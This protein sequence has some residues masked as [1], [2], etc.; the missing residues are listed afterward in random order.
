M[1][2]DE[3]AELFPE[4]GDSPEHKAILNLAKQLQRIRVER[5]EALTDSKAKEDAAQENLVGLM[6][7]AKLP[8][9]KHGGIQVNIKPRSER[10]K[11][12]VL[13]EDDDDETE[14]DE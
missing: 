10:V 7:E 5:K 14:D 6:H 8:A 13:A 9:F 12:K 1:A 3:Q 11:I 2:K 4:L